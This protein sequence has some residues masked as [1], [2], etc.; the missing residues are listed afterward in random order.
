[1][2]AKDTPFDCSLGKYCSLDPIM[3][4]LEKSLLI[5]RKNGPH[6]DIYKVLF[7]AFGLEN[8]NIDFYRGEKNR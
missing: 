4:L 3:I 1:M 8:Y 5:Q 6:K 2:T 7:D